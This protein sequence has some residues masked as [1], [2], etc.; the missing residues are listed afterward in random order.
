[1]CK[2]QEHWAKGWFLFSKSRVSWEFLEQGP[3]ERL[4]LQDVMLSISENLPPLA[5]AESPW[6][7]SALFLLNQHFQLSDCA[8]TKWNKFYPDHCEKI[9]HRQHNQENKVQQCPA[10]HGRDSVYLERCSGAAG[11]AVDWFKGFVAQR[12]IPGTTVITW[13]KNCWSYQQKYI[14]AHKIHSTS[15]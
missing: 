2:I 9:V 15:L 14:I 3:S 8:S 5:K 13:Q 10:V 11:A 4:S 12:T 6:K 1:M 7:W